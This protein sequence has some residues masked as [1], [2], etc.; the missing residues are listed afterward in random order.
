ME[1]PL[2]ISKKTVFAIHNEQLA[3]HGGSTG[4]REEGLLDSALGKPHNVFADMEDVD[5]FRLAASYAYGVARNH[6]FVDGNKRTALVIAIAFLDYNGWDVV[7]AREDEYITFL[8]LAE[9]TLSEEELAQ[10]FRS[11]VEPL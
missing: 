11:H 2:W 8:K 3:E 6:P 7:A 1:E 10:W 5:I 9:G 4:V